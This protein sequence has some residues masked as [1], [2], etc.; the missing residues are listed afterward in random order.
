MRSPSTTLL[1]SVLLASTACAPDSG[2]V[3]FRDLYERHAQLGDAEA[4]GLFEAC[5]SDKEGAWLVRHL[6]A[7][8]ADATTVRF[9]FSKTMSPERA[10]CVREYL[11]GLGAKEFETDTEF[12]QYGTWVWGST[13]E[14]DPND[15]STTSTGGNA[16]S[17]TG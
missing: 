5:P 10:A 17:S 2:D 4:V 12:A 1:A 3:S 7:P 14:N 8:Q 11:E 6:D 13:T 9:E 16:G 15:P